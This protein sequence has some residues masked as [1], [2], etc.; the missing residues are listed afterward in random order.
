M[1]YAM[2]RD[3]AVVSGVYDLK[4]RRFE[5]GG[6]RFLRVGEW[7]DDLHT[8]KP[9]TRL[10]FEEVMG[11][12][13][14]DAAHIYGGIVGI[15]TAFCEAHEIPYSGIPVGTIKRHVTGKGNAKKERVVEAITALGFTP[16]D[17]NEAD[18]LAILKCVQDGVA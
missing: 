16:Q 2:E 18:A 7:L 15:I 12:K 14:T 1:G 17:D 9:I 4:S 10:Y 6:M 11:H 8:G 5:G 3:G 13:G